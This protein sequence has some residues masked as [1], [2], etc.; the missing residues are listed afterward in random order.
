[1]AEKF[2]KAYVDKAHEYFDSSKTNDSTKDT[3]QTK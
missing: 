2:G 3:D 1:M